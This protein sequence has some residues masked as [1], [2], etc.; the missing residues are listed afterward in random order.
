MGLEAQPALLSLLPRVAAWSHRV[1]S[2]CSHQPGPA[3]PSHPAQ[4]GIFPTSGQ[5]LLSVSSS[6]FPPGPSAAAR[7]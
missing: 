1:T 7:P 5:F 3:E 6:S 4:A 2:P